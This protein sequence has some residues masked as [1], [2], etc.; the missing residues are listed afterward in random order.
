MLLL[1]S[2]R[3]FS[4]KKNLTHVTDVTSVIF[5]QN[6]LVRSLQPF[7]DSKINPSLYE[8]LK[9]TKSKRN[10]NKFEFHWN[11]QLTYGI[12]RI[13]LNEYYDKVILIRH[14]SSSNFNSLHAGKQH[15][16]SLS[17]KK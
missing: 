8:K 16:C 3:N 17:D 2:T 9:K 12:I 1:F 15:A 11:N 13:V 14:V 6:T 10:R 4:R 5:L 7:F